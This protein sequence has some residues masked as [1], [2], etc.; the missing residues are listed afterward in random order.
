MLLLT[1][2]AA[3]AADAQGIGFT[4]GGAIDPGQA[5]VGTY[6]ESPSIANHIRLRPGIDGGFGGPFSEAIVDFAFLYDIPFSPTSDWFVYQ[7]SGPTVTILRINEQHHTS[8]GFLGVFGVGNKKG[9]FF[10]VKINGGDGPNLRAGAG[11]T[12]KFHQP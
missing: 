3:P 12:I 8:G 1:C 10:E 11:Y 7:G 9:F 5:Y 4:G 6:F 2:W